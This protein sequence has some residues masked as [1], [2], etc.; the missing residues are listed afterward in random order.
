MVPVG[1]TLGFMRSIDFLE[2]FSDKKSWDNKPK[3]VLCLNAD[4]SMRKEVKNGDRLV[5]RM[6]NST[7]PGILFYHTNIMHDCL[8]RCPNI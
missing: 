1:M 8:E 7:V 4:F 6:N 5:Q 2:Y 3:M